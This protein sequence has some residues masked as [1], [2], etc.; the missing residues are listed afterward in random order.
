MVSSPTGDTSR[1][2]RPAVAVIAVCILVGG[3]VGGLVASLLGQVLVLGPLP[4]GVSVATSLLAGLL[5]ALLFFTGLFAG[6]HIYYVFYRRAWF[7]LLLSFLV[8]VFWPSLLP[9]LSEEVQKRLVSAALRGLLRDSHEAIAGL[10]PES[11]RASTNAV[12]A[13]EDTT[14]SLLA[15]A[16]AVTDAGRRTRTDE[17]IRLGIEA[18]ARASV[19][20]RTPWN[21]QAARSLGTVGWNAV[22][23][24]Q[25]QWATAAVQSLATVA[26][27]SD[28]ARPAAVRGLLEIEHEAKERRDPFVTLSAA[29][30]LKQVRRR[31]AGQN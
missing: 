10:T 12:A 6:H 7:A 23:T 18:L 2:N 26:T 31:S 29:Q 20:E 21:E 5:A 11:I 8:G 4:K 16:P 13:V 14:V 28:A 30:A 9:K 27:Q 24:G 1:S 19:D 17:Q 22:R 3:V 15:V 25:P